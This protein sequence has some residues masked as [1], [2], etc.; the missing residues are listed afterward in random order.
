MK[1][2]IIEV[3]T[4]SSS[5]FTMFEEFDKAKLMEEKTV[6]VRLSYITKTR[7][8][9]TMQLGQSRM[10]INLPIEGFKTFEK[11]EHSYFTGNVTVSHYF[12][13]SKKQNLEVYKEYVKAL[14]TKA[15]KEYMY[16]DLDEITVELEADRF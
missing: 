5:S 3:P 4:P 1:V 6:R 14:I 9:T 11:S 12:V 15:V 8:S 10:G 7:I 13:K 16:L 2:N